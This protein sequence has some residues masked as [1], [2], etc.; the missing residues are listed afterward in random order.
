MPTD[1][2]L[3]K[4]LTTMKIIWGAML[5]SLAVYVVIATQFGDDIRI[6]PGVMPSSPAPART[7][8]LRV[9]HTSAP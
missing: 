4:G 3:D 2:E 9:T 5:F 8:P 1:A 7:A 6:E